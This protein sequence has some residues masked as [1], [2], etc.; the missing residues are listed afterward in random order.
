MADK[1]SK[2]SEITPASTIAPTAPP[3]GKAGNPRSGLTGHILPSFWQKSAPSGSRVSIGA[4]PALHAP[5]A[6]AAS[7]PAIP[8]SVRWGR[9]WPGRFT[10]G[11]SVRRAT[12]LVIACALLSLGIYLRSEE[13]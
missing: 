12:M 10:H 11:A 6:T 8:A 2:T 3:T 7:A 9:W 4:P 5:D 1:N 13:R